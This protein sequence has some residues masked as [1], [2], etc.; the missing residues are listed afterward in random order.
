MHYRFEAKPAQTD[1]VTFTKTITTCQADFSW[2]KWKRYP[3]LHFCFFTDR[4]IT[5]P[6]FQIPGKM[7]SNGPRCNDES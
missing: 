7:S 2:G 5:G 1:N 3:C 6:S 4:F